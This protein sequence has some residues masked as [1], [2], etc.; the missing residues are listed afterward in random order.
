MSKETKEKAD[1]TAI[2]LIMFLVMVVLVVGFIFLK[3]WSDK[4]WNE[5]PAKQETVAQKQE[6]TE[7]IEDEEEEDKKIATISDKIEVVPTLLDKVSTNSAWCATFQLVW[8]DMQDEIVQQEIVFNPQLEVVKNLNKQSIKEKDL[9]DEY[10][11]K[12]YG[13][14]TLE[15]KD[16]IEKGIKEKFDQTSD[17]LD[18]LDWKNVPKND[19][20]YSSDSKT[21]LFYTMLYREFHFNKVFTLLKNDK[22]KGTE[23]TY[24][25]V[26]YFGIDNSTDERVYNQVDVLYY[27]DTEDFAVLLKTKEGDEVVLAKGNNGNTFED[28]YK[29]IMSKKEKYK[30]KTNFTKYDTLKVP[31]IKFDELK[32][33]TE[34]ENK[35]FMA[36]DGD[37]CIISKALQTI[38]FELDEKGGKIKS[39]AVIEMTKNAMAF[40][41]EVEY[42]YFDFD[43]TFTMFLVD[44]DHQDKP[45]FAANIDDITLYQ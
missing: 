43:S 6:E 37:E 29:T 28:I 19:S 5:K 32:E 24:S 10:Y 44:D 7:K 9:E 39:E 31:K 23:K 14:K 33:Y 12:I 4:K 11:Y 34:L 35:A 40:E 26:E 1:R 3:L 17:V 22:F 41:E 36:A 20:E 21:Y 13:L 38:K 16:K 27:N 42:R 45:Y 2:L 18:L 30:G 8:N 25:N 15:L